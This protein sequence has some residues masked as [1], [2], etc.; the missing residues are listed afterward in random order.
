MS[1]KIQSVE[2]LYASKKAGASPLIW[3][4]TVLLLLM[5]LAVV[6]LGAPVARYAFA[7]MPEEQPMILPQVTPTPF[8]E[9]PTAL[10][11]VTPTPKGE[12]VPLVTATPEPEAAEEEATPAPT[13]FLKPYISPAPTQE[14]SQAPEMAEPTETP[15]VLLQPAASQTPQAEGNEAVTEDGD[16]NETVSEPQVQTQPEASS[17]PEISAEPEV[18]AEPEASAEPEQTPVPQ[19]TDSQIRIFESIP[20]VVEAVNPAVVGVV[21]YQN[22]KGYAEPMAVGS[23]SGFV[24]SEDG[25][26]LT[27][28]HVVSGAV[29]LEVLFDDGSSVSAELVGKDTPSDIALLKIEREGLTVLPMGNSDYIRQGEYVLAIGNPLD[30]YQLYGTVTFGIISAVAREINIDGYVNTY[31]QTDA[32]INLGNSGGPLVNL[33]GQVVG[34]NTAKSV[35]AGYDENGNAVAAEGIGFALPI[36]KVIDIANQILMYGGVDRPGI[37]LQAVTVTDTQA[38]MQGLVAG[39]LVDSVTAGGPAEQAGLQADDIIVKLNGEVLTT[40][41]ELVSYCQSCAVGDSMTLTIYRSGQYLD[42]VLVVGNINDF[43]N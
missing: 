29:Y 43:S 22:V 17:E 15:R 18:V 42:V 23:G 28:A 12:K 4:L 32:A 30:S 10:P 25:Y 41:D 11:T 5:S 8:E 35:V 3:V 6:L 16:T 33:Q 13:A 19:E 14:A 39:V 9:K 36:N 27:N 20:D 34:M 2:E 38:R 21:N 40:V 31:L 37:G 26:I 7:Q 24:V 1:K